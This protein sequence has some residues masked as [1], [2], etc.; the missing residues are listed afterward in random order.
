M[1]KNSGIVVKN[2]FC[3]ITVIWSA[4]MLIEYVMILLPVSLSG[5]LFEIFDFLVVF[6][7]SGV[8]AVPILLL[9][10]IILMAVV[11][12]KYEKT[13]DTNVLN[14]ITVVLPVITFLVMLLTNFN[15][16]LQ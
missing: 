8:F 3:T 13:D 7:F 15:S 16:R 12:K 4:I 14:I 5:L 9:L 11:S 2:I 10:S 6:L 1:K